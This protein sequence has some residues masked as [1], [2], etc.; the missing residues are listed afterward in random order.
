MF[1]LNF[2]DLKLTF[3]S[4]RNRE[5]KVPDSLQIPEDC[6]NRASC[7]LVREGNTPRGNRGFRKEVK[8]GSREAGG[9]GKNSGKVWHPV[10][11]LRSGPGVSSLLTRQQGEVFEGRSSQD[12]QH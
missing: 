9:E 10:G 8:G 12:L 5:D 3:P 7:W 4:P 2:E 6:K 1:F 11:S